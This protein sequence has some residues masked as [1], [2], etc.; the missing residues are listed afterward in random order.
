VEVRVPFLE[1]E[2]I[3]FALHLPA[4]AKLQHGI[5]KWAVKTAA[6][7]HLPRDLVLRPKQGFWT[8]QGFTAG[9]TAL[10]EDGFVAD[11]LHWPR[12]HRPE[13]IAEVEADADERGRLVGLELWGRL[14]LAGESVERLG[15][16][17]L[18]T[19]G[20]AAPDGTSARA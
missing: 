14:F 17:L 10:L 19:H 7:R 5:G 20:A 16:R 13:L 15:E 2:L 11:L 18:A 9:T 6:L 1:N 4:R 3:D 8:P 12:R